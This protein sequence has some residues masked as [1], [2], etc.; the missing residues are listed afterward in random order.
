VAYHFYDLATWLFDTEGGAANDTLENRYGLT[1]YD[2]LS[3]DGS[4]E[5]AESMASGGGE[6][7]EAS[8]RM[9]ES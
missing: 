3:I 1:P 7:D 8:P 2:G 6:S 9:L 5:G 4:D